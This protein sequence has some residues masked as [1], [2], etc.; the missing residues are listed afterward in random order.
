VVAADIAER[1]TLRAGAG[2]GRAMADAVITNPPF[3]AGASTTAPPGAAR[4]A[5]HILGDD[6]LEPWLRAAA[7]MLKPR[8]LLVVIFRADGLDALFAAT[9]SRFGGLDILPIHP[10]RAAPAHRVLVRAVK[11]SRAASR[12]LPPLV[13]HGEFFAM[14][15]ACRRSIRPGAPRRSRAVQ[16]R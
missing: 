6:G 13:L 12:L 4:A 10:R 9:A 8:G 3:H 7:S 1:E 14:A 15:R 5:A 16:A 2:L 11:G